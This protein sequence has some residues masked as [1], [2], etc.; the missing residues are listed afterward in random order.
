MKNRWRVWLVGV[1]VAALLVAGGIVVG[2]YMNGGGGNGDGSGNGDGTVEPTESVEPTA[3][4]D[5]DG[6]GDETRHV[7]VYFV[8]G[9][10]VGVARR[11][12]PATEAVATAA[13]EELLAGPTAQEE[14]W[15][16]GSQIPEGT[17]LNG[18]TIADGTAR[19]D[20]SGNF[21]TGGGTL[22]MAL[23]LAQVAY[24]LTQFPTVDRVVFLLDGEVVEVFSGEGI[25]LDGPVTRATCEEVTPALLVESP[26]PGETITSPVRITGT[27][28]TFE[29]AFIVRIEGPNGEI[30]AEE[31]AMATSGSG[32]RGTFDVSAPFSVAEE[33]DGTLVVYESSAQDGSP[34]N[35]I[36]IPVRLKP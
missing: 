9:E 34:I 6:D 30:L 16:L 3:Q 29:A 27:G 1:A 2:Q 23:R 14:A 13:M 15:G 35:V 28:N 20:L 18:V 12:I 36:E 11:E 17:K 7:L 22:S 32:T 19:V 4:T 21:E 26:A 25:I 33:C 24:T 8:R 10:N 5:G 31:P